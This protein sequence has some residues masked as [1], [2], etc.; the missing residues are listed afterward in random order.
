VPG[1]RHKG[2]RK[3]PEVCQEDARK[4]PKRCQEGAGKAC[5]EG[6]RKM[7]EERQKV[8]ILST[9]FMIKFFVK[10]EEMAT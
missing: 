5:Q 9:S 3:V 2:A 8:G 6:V 7:A 4:V 1:R 10:L